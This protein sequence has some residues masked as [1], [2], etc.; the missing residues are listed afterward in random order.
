MGEA[1]LTGIYNT[2][3]IQFFLQNG[4]AADDRQGLGFGEI[5][6]RV[7]GTAG[8]FNPTASKIVFDTGCP[9]WIKANLDNFR[10]Y[11]WNNYDTDKVK[12]ELWFYVQYGYDGR[13]LSIMDNISAGQSR[14]SAWTFYNGTATTSYPTDATGYITASILDGHTNTPESSSNDTKIPNTSWVNTKISN[15]TLTGGNDISID[16]KAINYTGPR[17]YRLATRTWT[18]AQWTQYCERG[19]TSN[20]SPSFTVAGIRTGDLVTVEGICSDRNNANV[21][22]W[23]IANGEPA[24]E[25]NN[26]SVTFLGLCIQDS[27]YVPNP[28]QV[29][30]SLPSSPDAN[31]I[32]IVTG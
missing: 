2:K 16:N 26:V 28:I 27:F 19:V 24:A 11:Y 29:V 7:E 21:L 10:L 6:A 23:G 25:T 1:I 12:V 13:S 14:Q 18:Y 15:I 31:T 3:Q 30:T 20:I 8:I 4:A 5:C 22:A 9:N 32:Y 17:Y